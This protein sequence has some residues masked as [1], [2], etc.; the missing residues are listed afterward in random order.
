VEQ[1]SL[2]GL[3]SQIW[4]V[5][6]LTRY[7]RQSLESDYRL[8][9]IWVSGEV[10]NASRPAS[11]HFYFTLKD[12]QASLRCVMWRSEVSAQ[13][14]LPRDGD[15]IEVH[16]H[17]GVYE[18]GGQYQLYAD[19]L[20]K[21]GEGALYQRFLHLKA[22]LEA[23]GL[24]DASRKRELPPWPERL[25]IVT[26]PTGAALQDVLNVLRRRFPLTTV[27]LA[28]TPVQG[29]EAPAGIVDALQALN[30][31][32]RVDV[33]LLVR[34][35]GSIEDL[36]AFND[37]G[38]AHAIAASQVPVVA[39]IGHASDLVIAD[40]VADVHA[41]TPSA[42]AEMATPDRQT[43]VQALHD[44]LLELGQVF[45]ERLLVLRDNLS[46]LTRALQL[47]SPRAKIDGARQ[48][49]DELS[50][51]TLAEMRHALALRRAAVKGAL[52]TL[53]A[54]GPESVLSRGYAI[55]RLAADDK[56]VRSTQQVA[57]GDSLNLRLLDGTIDAT[58][59]R[60]E[61][62]PEEEE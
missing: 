60:V 28:P 41:P 52:N 9:D 44:L 43:L 29:D 56:V 54:V 57:V 23:E 19:E 10:S 40:L 32:G 1:F 48:R 5:A 16:G 46:R 47:A 58:T 34:G 11:G 37:E 45:G 49:V 42:A 26:S 61:P 50:A 27:I 25:G 31:F 14:Y 39:G 35:G 20:Q 36:W 8:G 18:A 3:E 17:I 6:D 38:V 12:E 51:R 53:R 4:S 59:D 62:S 15:S 13:T 7:I 22:R 30:Q 24:F 2:F 21:A 55:V 33:I